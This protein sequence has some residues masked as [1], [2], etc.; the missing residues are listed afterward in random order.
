MPS[1]KKPAI[2]GY[3]WEVPSPVSLTHLALVAV[4]IGSQQFRDRSQAD[5]IEK[6]QN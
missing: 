2:D 3:G 6:R 4:A 1:V 5:A